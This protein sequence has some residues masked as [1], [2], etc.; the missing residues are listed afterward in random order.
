MIL[1]Q[2]KLSIKSPVTRSGSGIPKVRRYSK[3]YV[4][5]GE[6]GNAQALVDANSVIPLRYFCDHKAYIN[7][8]HYYRYYLRLSNVQNDR[9]QDLHK[10]RKG[11]IRYRK[12]ILSR[13]N[14]VESLVAN[15]VGMTGL[16]L[17]LMMGTTSKSW[18]KPKS[19]RGY[20]Q[21]HTR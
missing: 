3:Y 2:L 1:R 13:S 21:T 14:V 12:F 7:Y 4:S 16:Y 9:V 18:L 15:T 10:C 20:Q 17:V 6:N 8:N 11:L 5:R 19:I